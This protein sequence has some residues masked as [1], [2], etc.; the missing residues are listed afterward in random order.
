MSSEFEEAPAEGELEAF[1][2]AMSEEGLDGQPEDGLQEGDGAGQTDAEEAEVGSQADEPGAEGA[3]AEIGEGGTPAGPGGDAEDVQLPEGFESW[4]DYF[5]RTQQAT[6]QLQGQV[7]QTQQF[8]QAQAQQAAHYRRLLAER[9]QQARAQ[10]NAW[11]APAGHVPDEV[12]FAAQVYGTEAFAKLPEGVKVQAEQYVA[13]QREI[14][15][16]LYQD[17]AG[18][19]QQL[20]APMFERH[21]QEQAQLRQEIA[22]LRAEKFRRDHADLLGEDEGVREFLELSRMSPRQ[23]AMEVMRLKRQTVQGTRSEREHERKERDREAKRVAARGNRKRSQARAGRAQPPR[24]S[25][26]DAAN[27]HKVAE[28]VLEDFRLGG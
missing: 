27:P 16:R 14:Q 15:R 20:V 13:R 28:S 5:Q 25:K 6:Q 26:E 3:E 17:P 19:V 4:A 22:D 23:L 9:D 24:L 2:G 1:E 7:G 21:R 11:A 18:A 12:I 8:A 10:Q